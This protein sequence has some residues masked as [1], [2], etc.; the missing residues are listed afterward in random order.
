MRMTHVLTH[1][2]CRIGH[3]R[4]TFLLSLFLLQGNS[5]HWNNIVADFMLYLCFCLSFWTIHLYFCSV[6]PFVL[7]YNLP[8]SF[9]F[10]IKV[11]HLL[12]FIKPPFSDLSLTSL[13]TYQSSQDSNE[14]LLHLHHPPSRRFE[15]RA[16]PTN[17]L[18]PSDE[19]HLLWRQVIICNFGTNYFF[20]Q[21][22]PF[23]QQ[24]SHYFFIQFHLH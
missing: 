2:L 10:S 16:T 18:Q 6:S 21:I 23:F 19:W 20:I 7:W 15:N 14:P 1:S 11:L 24:L 22:T 4:S 17:R 12:S 9:A 5:L 13:I 8:L 3:T